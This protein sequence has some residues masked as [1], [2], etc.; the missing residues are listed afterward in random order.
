VGLLS[1]SDDGR[2]QE[3]SVDSSENPSPL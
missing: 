2:W 1:V 3:G